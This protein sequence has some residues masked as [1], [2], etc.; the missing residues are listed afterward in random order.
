MIEQQLE[1]EH[2]SQYMLYG[3]YEF[4]R[5][6]QDPSAGEE[7]WKLLNDLAAK[8][9]PIRR[10][11]SGDKSQLNRMIS[12]DDGYYVGVAFGSTLI[13]L[14]NA[15]VLGLLHDAKVFQPLHITIS[16]T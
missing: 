16:P 1:K 12:L 13:V 4:S 6:G 14:Q 11:V 9:T 5:Q 8:N 3:A 2:E 15:S 10:L 7:S